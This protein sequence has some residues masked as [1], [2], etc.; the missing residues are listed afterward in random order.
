MKA[1]MG[2]PDMKLPVQYALSYPYRLKSNFPR[3]NFMDYPELTFEKVDKDLFRNLNLA[4]EAMI[5]GGNMPCILNAANEVAV[6][7][8]LGGR[9]GFLEIPKSIEKTMRTHRLIYKPVLADIFAA[10]A[11]A[12]E[13]AEELL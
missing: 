12:R 6:E 9:I 7:A 3:F 13:T 1:Q 11:W 10:D 2:L 8:F 5:K 4:Y